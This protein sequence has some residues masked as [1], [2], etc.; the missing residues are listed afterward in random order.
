MRV[1]R[2]VATETDLELDVSKYIA[3]LIRGDPVSIFKDSCPYIYG[4]WLSWLIVTADC[5]PLQAVV[6]AFDA[7]VSLNTEN[8]KIYREISGCLPL[9]L[10]MFSWY[11]QLMPLIKKPKRPGGHVGKLTIRQQ[12]QSML[13][14]DLTVKS[15]M[16]LSV[17]SV[18]A[19]TIV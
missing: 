19:E 1:R 13:M 11:G 2:H 7:V 4:A 15:P 5:S 9:R 12:F 8:A 18:E 6:A 10:V 17:Y 3:A 14:C 16:M